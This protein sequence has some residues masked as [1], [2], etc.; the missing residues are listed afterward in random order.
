MFQFLKV[1]KKWKLTWKFEAPLSTHYKM[2]ALSIFASN[3]Q[4]FILFDSM[5]LIYAKD[6]AVVSNLG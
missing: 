4:K 3:C 6:N 1:T 5:Y 2:A